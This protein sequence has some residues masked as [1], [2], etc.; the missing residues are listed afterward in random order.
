M[1]SID[2]LLYITALAVE[3][4]VTISLNIARHDPECN[5]KEQDR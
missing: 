3:N 2:R 4:A 1:I 5:L